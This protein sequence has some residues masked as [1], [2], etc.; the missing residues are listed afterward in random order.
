LHQVDARAFRHC[1][2]SDVQNCKPGPLFP[3][4]ERTAQLVVKSIRAR[5]C[6]DQ[7]AVTR[8]RE[9]QRRAIF[10]NCRC[11]TSA[12]VFFSVPRQ[13]IHKCSTGIN[14]SLGGPP[15]SV[16]LLRSTR[17]GAAR[18]LQLD[19]GALLRLGAGNCVAI[20]LCGR[21]HG[22][23]LMEYCVAS[24]THQP[25]RPT[26]QLF[27]AHPFPHRC[28]MVLQR[29]KRLTAEFVGT[30]PFARG[31]ISIIILDFSL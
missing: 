13:I 4:S 2:S 21:F 24:F 12:T 23:R 1:H 26:A 20:E 10:S 14:D 7:P 3:L 16:L 17:S 28:A 15:P 29:H 19:V 6:I 5:F 27:P 25:A 31:A 18:R 8:A 9:L 22:F 30:L 11:G